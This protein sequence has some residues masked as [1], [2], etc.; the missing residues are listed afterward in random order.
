MDLGSSH[1]SDHGAASLAGTRAPVRA[2]SWRCVMVDLLSDGG[3][4]LLGE[5]LLV[6]A[7]RLRWTRRRDVEA[8]PPLLTHAPQLLAELLPRYDVDEKIYGVIH[9]GY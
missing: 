3:G 4:R 8:P 9:F 5:R 1:V 2:L 7:L 6:D